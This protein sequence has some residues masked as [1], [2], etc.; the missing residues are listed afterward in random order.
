[1]RRFGVRPQPARASPRRSV[2]FLIRAP[3]SSEITRCPSKYA[4]QSGSGGRPKGSFVDGENSGGN[5]GPGIVASRLLS[6]DSHPMSQ[7]RV[8]QQPDDRQRQSM[9]IL[10]IR[11]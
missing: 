9:R 6:R 1:M 8:R 2:E 7:R 11:Q 5:F 3:I 4:G 10:R